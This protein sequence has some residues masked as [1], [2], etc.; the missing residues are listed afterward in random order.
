MIV[1]KLS[2]INDVLAETGNNLVAVADDGSDEWNVCSP[3]Y[4]KAVENTLEA[5]NWLFLKTIATLVR[6]GDSP[7]PVYT[8]AMALPANA[9]HVLW[10]RLALNQQQQ[11]PVDYKIMSLGDTNQTPVICLNLSGYTA[12]AM[13]LIDSQATGNWP[14]LFAE[15][16]R[17]WVRA[18]IYRGLHEDPVQADKEEGKAMIALQTASTRSDQNN[19]KRRTFNS[20][21]ITARRVRRP[22]IKTPFDWGGTGVPN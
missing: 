7:D 15:I 21:A 2:I 3:V 17:F 20:P 16:I 8:D 12:N 5:R 19:P 9:L 10:V 14:P 18:A 1:D 4:D 22:W 6:A 11:M 13:F